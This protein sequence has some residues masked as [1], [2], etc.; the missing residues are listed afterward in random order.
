[1]LIAETICQN[2]TG[3]NKKHQNNTHRVSFIVCAKSSILGQLKIFRR[4][5]RQGRIV[6]LNVLIY[7]KFLS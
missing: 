5:S 6:P 7:K 4:I 2:N 3:Y 1:M